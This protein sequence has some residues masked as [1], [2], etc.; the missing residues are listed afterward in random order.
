MIGTSIGIAIVIIVLGTILI[1]SEIKYGKEQSK[2][3]RMAAIREAS[4]D[5]EEKEKK[6]LSA[7]QK[8]RAEKFGNGEVSEGDVV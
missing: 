5:R 7:R 2:K 6:E 3:K 8:K 4:S 1:K